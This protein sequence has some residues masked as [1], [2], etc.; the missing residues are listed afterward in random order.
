MPPKDIRF[1][2]FDLILIRGDP[3]MRAENANALLTYDSLY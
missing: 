1:V 2:E 3:F